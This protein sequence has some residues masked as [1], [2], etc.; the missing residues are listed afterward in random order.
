MRCIYCYTDNRKENENRLSFEEYCNILDQGK[1]LG[2]KLIRISGEGESLLDNKIF[3]DPMKKNS[4]NSEFPL[5]DY[6]N[7]IGIYVVF[8][9]N[10]ALITK[11]RP[12]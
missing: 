11:Q 9:T 6:A 10:G 2:M 3:Y 5:V 1:E 7:E 8:F 12:V 4:L